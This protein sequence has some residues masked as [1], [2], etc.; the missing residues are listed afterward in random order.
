MKTRIFYLKK[1]LKKHRINEDNLTWLPSDASTRRYARVYKGKNSY[2][3]M[4]SPLTE[5]P[6]EF[7]Q[8]TQLLR[9]NKLPAPRIFAKDLRHG[10]MLLEDFGKERLSHFAHKN[11]NSLE[12]YF[13]AIDLLVRVQKITPSNSI[14]KQSLQQWIKAMNIFLNYFFPYVIGKE[15]SNKAKEDFYALWERL[16]QKINLLPSAI[17]L[18]DYHLDNL[19]HKKDGTL[20][21]LDFQDATI[22]PVFYDLIAL[23]ENDREPLPESKAQQVLK[24]YLEL[25]PELD[26]KKYTELFPVIAAQWHTRVIGVFVRMCVRMKNPKYLSFLK[27]DW[28]LLARNLKSPLLNEYKAWLNKYV[29]T[30]N[31]NIPKNLSEFKPVRT[32]MMLAAG[33]GTRM[34]PLTNLRPKP[35]IKVNKKCLCQYTLDALL[36]HQIENFV[37]NTSY[38]GEQLH[39]YL[40]DFPI[41]VHF[42]DEKE[43]LN[44]GGGVKKA[45]PIL[46][47]TG[48]D[49][50][51]VVNSDT[52]WV[53]TQ[54]AL[55]REMEK[56]WDPQKMDCLL[57]LIPTKNVHGDLYKGDY[58]LK[59]NR[60]VR[61]HP[62]DDVA[63]YMFMGVQILHPRAFDKIQETSFPLWKQIYDVAERNHRMGY[64]IFDGFWFNVG[65]PKAVKTATSFL[66]RL[67]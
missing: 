51:F 20:G 64:I 19:M 29:P 38:K 67:K 43:L 52:I 5:K 25:R 7:Y 37:I 42:S 55:L 46:K 30:K 50:F 49:G 26:Q 18:G 11:T 24:H 2:I 62:E 48:N 61:R 4:D 27:N 59:D 28:D 31:R 41:P 39:E 53:D 66:K 14:P 34:R 13:D 35:L 12:P 63:P 57:A 47:K 54:T 1:F 36:K 10:Y 22:G 9:R 16:S 40:K 58:F 56:A 8:I 23:I 3:F 17:C 32:A 44:T 60:P 45:L 33:L 65:T 15:L 21:L 6:K